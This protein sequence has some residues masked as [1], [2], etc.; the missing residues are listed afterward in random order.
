MKG[1]YEIPD[2]INPEARE[3]IT[4]ILNINP[5]ERYTIE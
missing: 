4:L 1:E 2:F 5:K 3:L